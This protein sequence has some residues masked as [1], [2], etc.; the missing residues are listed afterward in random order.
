MFDAK[1][2]LQ[3]TGLDARFLRQARAEKRLPSDF[4]ENRLSL[5]QA[6]ALAAWAEI[7]R[8]APLYGAVS[9]YTFLKA[10]FAAR[11]IIAK[12]EDWF[13][14]YAPDEDRT[15]EATSFVTAGDLGSS[16]ELAEFRPCITF[17]PMRGCIGRLKAQLT[18]LTEA[19]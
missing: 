7:G 12:P 14:L 11:D 8:H 6:V 9:R 17:V 13:C 19:A 5:E 10:E 1:E 3:L 15:G 4:P 18:E 16:V 2:V